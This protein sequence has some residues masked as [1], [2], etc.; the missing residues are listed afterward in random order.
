V[1]VV[2][3][4]LSRRQER[5]LRGSLLLRI[6]QNPCR[7]KRRRSYCHVPPSVLAP[8]SIAQ[9]SLLLLEEENICEQALVDY[10][11]FVTM[12]ND[13]LDKLTVAELRSAVQYYDRE[14]QVRN[15]RGRMRVD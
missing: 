6:A 11:L 5:P 4:G 2:P 7:A 9:D 15:N 14:V 13:D 3:L 12:E 8:N 1:E 10:T